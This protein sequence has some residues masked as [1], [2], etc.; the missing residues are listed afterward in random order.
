MSAGKTVVEIL[1]EVAGVHGIW[2]IPVSWW[3]STHQVENKAR[4]WIMVIWEENVGEGSRACSH[5]WPFPKSCYSRD[6]RDRV[7]APF[8]VDGK[9]ANVSQRKVG[10]EGDSLLVSKSNMELPRQQGRGRWLCRGMGAWGRHK[11]RGEE[12]RVTSPSAA[13]CM[14]PTATDSIRDTSIFSC[15]FSLR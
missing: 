15:H 10:G 9:E 4:I 5:L 2:Q 8:S 1:S 13:P 7:E 3:P 11:V 12:D 14:W 6:P